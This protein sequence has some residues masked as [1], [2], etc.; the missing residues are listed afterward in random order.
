MKLDHAMALAAICALPM[1]LDAQPSTYE[2]RP[3]ITRGTTIGG[4]P[5][6]ECVSVDGSALNDSAEFAFVAS[7]RLDNDSG[8]FSTERKIFT[9][10]RLVAQ[11]G[12]EIDGKFIDMLLYPKLSINKRGQVAYPAMYGDTREQARTHDVKLGIFVDNHFAMTVLETGRNWDFVLT[13]DGRVL[14][15]PARPPS[16]YLYQKQT[17]LIDRLRANVPQRL[18]FP[19]PAQRR[20]PN[21]LYDPRPDLSMLGPNVRGQVLLPMNLPDS[22]FVILLAT[23]AHR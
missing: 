7:C 3:V 16:Q 15:D 12:D 23:P 9:A 20:V 13:D 22:G 8:S 2:L 18:P 5:L 6:S 19:I 4:Q 1:S 10:R 21:S 11:D 14:L 17:P